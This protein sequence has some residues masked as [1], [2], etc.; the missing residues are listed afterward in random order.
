MDEYGK[1]QFLLIIIV[2]GVF[3]PEVKYFCNSY[4]LL[5][6]NSIHDTRVFQHSHKGIPED[7]ACNS[8]FHEGYK[9]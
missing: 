7:K 9:A 6:C 3:F 1:M 4:Q 8:K 5:K 2:T